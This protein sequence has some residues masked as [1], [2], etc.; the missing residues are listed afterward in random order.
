MKVKNQTI[1]FSFSE[2][3]SL[4]KSVAKKLSCKFSEIISKK[5]PDGE[6]YV[7]IKEKVTEKNFVLI[8][9]F[10]KNPNSKIIESLLAASIAQEYG[11]RK[12]ILVAT[13]LP[14]MRQ[15]FRFNEYEA[16]SS[17]KILPILCSSF[18]EVLAVDPH[19]H[20]ID[21]LKKISSNARSITV[22]PLII[23]YIKKKFLDYEIVGP[24]EESRQ[25][26]KRI[27]N[28]LNLNYSIL[29]KHR[30]SSQKVYIES[31]GLAKNV[32]IID[33][34]ISTGHTVLETIKK[35]KKRGSKKFAVI[36]IHGIFSNQSDK[37]I[38][39][40]SEIITTNT[41][42]NKYAKIDIAPILSEELKKT[43][44]PLP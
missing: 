21:S 25:W 40:Y 2:T 14:Y 31:K 41:I 42:P 44:I 20:R 22:I 7:R 18:D 3:S 38:S 4:A 13:Y 37:E 16:V 19:L 28:S 8:S 6:S 24:D 23:D 10:A 17:K 26:D 30:I 27:A 9:S 11:A 5:F 15:D 32:L 35:A 39:K 43:L 12:L 34:I 1:V 29:K 33:D 36:A